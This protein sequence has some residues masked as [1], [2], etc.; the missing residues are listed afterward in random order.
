MKRTGRFVTFTLV[1]CI[2]SIYMYFYYLRDG[3]LS[4]ME[5][6][7]LP[8]MLLTAWYFG[9]QYDKAKYYSEKDPLTGV[10]NRRIIEPFFLRITSL[11]ERN[12][13]TVGFFLIDV[14]NFKQINDNFGHQKG[15]ELLKLLANLLVNCLRKSD[16]VAR[17]GGDEFILICPNLKNYEGIDEIIN[18]IHANLK[19]ISLSE[20]EVSISIGAAI[21]PTE[22]KTIDKL[23]SMADKK[24]YNMKIQHLAE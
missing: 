13:Q 22:G 23:L 24:M 15:D 6:F 17:W 14:D 10:Y 11:A 20:V 21:Y 19:T 18:R 8:I 3:F 5:I 4:K 9:K 7:G 1:L 16:I 12:R 2:N